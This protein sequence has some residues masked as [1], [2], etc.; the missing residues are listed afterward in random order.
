MSKA[1]EL[2]DITKFFK[3][4]NIPTD[5]EF[6]TENKFNYY[7]KFLDRQPLKLKDRNKT[8]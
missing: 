2:D 5:T 1:S 3:K 6:S 8:D 4:L 7:P